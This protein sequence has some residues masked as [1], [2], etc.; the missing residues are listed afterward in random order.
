L[1]GGAEG[2]EPTTVT[3]NVQGG[4]KRT[5]KKGERGHREKG[6]RVQIGRKSNR[7][8]GGGRR[9]LGEKKRGKRKNL[10]KNKRS[11]TRR[12]TGG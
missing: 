6:K 4:M 1:G 2:K 10:K 7:V 8:E 9:S 11:P 3:A 12:V 5:L